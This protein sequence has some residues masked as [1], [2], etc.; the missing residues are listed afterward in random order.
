VIAQPRF[1]FPATRP[2]RTPREVQEEAVLA[3]P[4]I[5]KLATLTR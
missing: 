5:D 1:Q 2:T 3:A 4:V